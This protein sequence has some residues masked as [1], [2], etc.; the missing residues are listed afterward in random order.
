MQDDLL[1]STGMPPDSRSLCHNA[2]LEVELAKAPRSQHMADMAGCPAEVVIRRPPGTALG[3]VV[4]R[5]RGVA[6]VAGV[7]PAGAIAAWN[8]KHPDLAVRA[9]DTIVAVDG[10]RELPSAEI[11]PESTVTVLRKPSFTEIRADIERALPG[12]RLDIEP[13]GR[14]MGLEKGNPCFSFGSEVEDCCMPDALNYCGL[15]A[16]MSAEIEVEEAGNPCF[17]GTSGSA[18]AAREAARV[19]MVLNDVLAEAQRAM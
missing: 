18:F 7:K 4:Y 8:R 15:V 16:H 1:S 13:D 5:A 3:L 14:V 10:L 11:Q 19:Q 6:I 17:L 12:F 2:G 9:G